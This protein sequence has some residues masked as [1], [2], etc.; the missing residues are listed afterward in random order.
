MFLNNEFSQLKIYK[1]NLIILCSK[2]YFVSKRKRNK[3]DTQIHFVLLSEVI[4]DKTLK[5]IK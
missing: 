5:K 4:L 1:N 3:I 2:K